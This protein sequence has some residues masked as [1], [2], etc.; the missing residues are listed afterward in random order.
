MIESNKKIAVVTLGCPKNQVDSEVIAGELVRGGM[1][2]VNDIEKADTILINTCGFIEAAKKESIEAILKAVELKKNGGERKIVVCGCLS[3]RYKGK[4]EK[5]IPEVDAYFGV[6]PFDEVGRFLLGSSYVWDE[7]AFG[8]RIL[9]ILSHTAYLKIAD[10]CD[11][12]CTFC[13]IPMIKGSYKSRSIDNL[14]DEAKALVNRGVKELILVAQDTTAY[15]SDLKDGT[16]LVSLLKQLVLIDNLH[17]IRI[18]YTYPDSVTDELIEVIS[19]EEKIC[20]YLDV[21]F[22][23]ISDSVLKAMGRRSRKESIERL[24]TKLR[25]MVP[26]IVLRTTFIVGF[27]GETDEMFQELVDFV[28]RARFERM[29]VF[30]YSPE[31]GTKAYHMKSTVPKKVAEERYRILMEIQKEISA[32]INCSLESKTFPVIVDG[33]DKS[34]ELFFGRTQGDAPDVDQTV[35]IKG[36]TSIGEIVH[37]K[38]EG[39]SAYDLMG[40]VLQNP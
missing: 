20:K 6:E 9:P 2:L 39:S 3:Q 11:H 10:G 16:D 19:R 31:E 26:G 24:I 40:R 21:P 32:D 18:M 5:E 33:Y 8:R 1:A 7:K 13:A 34:Q 23:H 35:W 36:K 17:W 12:G 28:Q 38:I 27:P 25:N 15:G 29:G 37:V 14:I 4:I 30:V 22:Q